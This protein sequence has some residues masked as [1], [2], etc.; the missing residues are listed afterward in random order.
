MQYSRIKNRKLKNLLVKIKNLFKFK[1]N[2]FNIY[3][4]A[5]LIAS[6]TWIISLFISWFSVW[7]EDKI[8]YNWFNN[9]TFLNSFLI[10]ILFILELFFLISSNKK[11]YIKLITKINLKDWKI[12]VSINSIIFLLSLIS[13]FN[14]YWLNTFYSN[15]IIWK[16]II[17]L[18]S[19]SVI[20]IFS[21]LKLK[22]ETN[23]EQIIINESKNTKINEDNNMKLPI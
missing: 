9:I 7:I 8:N 20:L 14:I 12:F 17:L 11:E 18:I 2:N 15:I 22:N 6:I 10:I 23:I 1:I 4:K 5:I 19:T 21:S 13:L 3:K 16:W